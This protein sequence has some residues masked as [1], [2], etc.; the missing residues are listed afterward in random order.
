MPK[1]A[2]EGV[3]SKSYWQSALSDCRNLRKLT[4]VAVMAAVQIA[5]SSFFIPV[6]ENLRVYFSFTAASLA[7]TVC[8]PVMAVIYGAAADLLGFLI[9]PSGAFFPGYTLSSMLGALLYALFLYRARMSVLRIFLAKLSVNALVNVG[10]GPIWSTI[11]YEKGYFYYLAGS[12]L[13]NALLLIPEVILMVLLLKSLLPILNRNGM[14]IREQ[15]GK[16]GW[17]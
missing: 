14:V 8:G 6:G 3:L 4:F 16:F 17:F 9:H 15:D 2:Y 12:A 11:L 5:I 1:N 7:C 10:L 13:K